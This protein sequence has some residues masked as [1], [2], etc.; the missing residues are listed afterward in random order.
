MSPFGPLNPIILNDLQNTPLF[1]FVFNNLAEVILALFLLIPSGRTR[2]EAIPLAGQ[3]NAAD[4]S[5][6]RSKQL[7]TEKLHQ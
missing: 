1:P 4:G 2:R 7:L 5:D 6:A 3:F